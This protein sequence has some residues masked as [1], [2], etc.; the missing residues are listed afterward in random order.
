[1]N[2]DNV[3]KIAGAFYGLTMALQTLALIVGAW[4]APAKVFAGWCAIL[5]TDLKRITG[6]G[7]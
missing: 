3:I 1:M 7:Q 2:F 6:G 5:G 4:W